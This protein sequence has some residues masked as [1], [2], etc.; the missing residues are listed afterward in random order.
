V[1]VWARA[2]G[3]RAF[4]LG[5]RGPMRQRLNTRVLEG[6]K[7]AT[8]GLWQHDYLDEHEAIDEVGERQ[9]LLDD[10]GNVVAIVEITRVEKHR[11]VDVPWEFAD[12]E[13]EDFRSIEHWREGHTSY[14]A[15]Q[16]IEIGEDTL[17]V[18]VWFRLVDQTE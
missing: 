16:G 10:N 18:C 15:Q 12:A 6:E 17:F 9:A 11:F 14:Y 7:V 2:K 3:L 5:T 8:A 4:E 13:G 1:L